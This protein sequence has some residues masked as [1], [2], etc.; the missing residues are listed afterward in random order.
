MGLFTQ[1]CFSK[2]PME[3]M[4][5]FSDGHSNPI[6]LFELFSNFFHL[7]QL[8]IY[9]MLRI[10]LLLADVLICCLNIFI[11][12]LF[13]MMLTAGKK[14]HKLMLPPFKPQTFFSILIIIADPYRQTVKFLFHLTRKHSFNRLVS[15]SL[16]YFILDL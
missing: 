14:K 15:T 7:F 11:Q 8:C 1:T 4:L 6:T 9:S 5:E 13:F 16:Q 2:F 3:S 12:F 10:I